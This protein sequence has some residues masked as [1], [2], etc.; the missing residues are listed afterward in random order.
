VLQFFAEH[1]APNKQQTRR[2]ELAN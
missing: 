1:L 2:S